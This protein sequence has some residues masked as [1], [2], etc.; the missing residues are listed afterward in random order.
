MTFYKS[1]HNYVFSISALQTTASIDSESEFPSH[2]Q[3]SLSSSNSDDFLSDCFDQPSTGVTNVIDE[4]KLYLQS[5]DKLLDNEDLLTF[6]KRQ[7]ALYPILYS[8]ACDILII[9]ATNTAAERLFSASG[10]T[11][12]N[13]RNRLSSQKV[14]KL[15]F[16]KKN[17]LILKKIFGKT[18]KLN[19]DDFYIHSMVQK[20][21]KRSHESVSSTDSNHNDDDDEED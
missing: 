5:T 3:T 10:K 7:K 1:I 17:L 2:Q 6:W 8:I 4:L 9:P 13:T 14:D 12:T 19:T 20:G 15:M 11:V 21:Q 16:I 18:E